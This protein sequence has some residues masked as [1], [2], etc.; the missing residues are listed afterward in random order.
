[1]AEVPALCPLGASF[2]GSRGPAGQVGGSWDRGLGGGSP[3]GWGW[4]R[5]D[6]CRKGGGG[7]VTAWAGARGRGVLQSEILQGWAWGQR[8]VGG[9][10][11]PHTS[12]SCLTRGS[13]NRS[14]LRHRGGPVPTPS[15]PGPFLREPL[16][17]RS[18]ESGGP[19]G[20]A[21]WTL[22]LTGV[23]GGAGGSEGRE[24]PSSHGGCTCCPPVMEEARQ[25]A[26]RGPVSGHV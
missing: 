16:P 6:F 22:G 19:C 15:A 20:N 1:M 12:S 3:W 11:R 9:S 17:V 4:G 10:R 23:G 7:V 18:E 5:G 13:R 2:L 24:R 26:P 14:L 8:Q 25:W 21:H